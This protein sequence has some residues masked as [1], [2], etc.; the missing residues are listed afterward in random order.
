MNENNTKKSKQKDLSKVFRK[1]VGE[2]NEQTN[3][4]DKH[5]K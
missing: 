2:T 1:K 3:Q 5:W 4:E